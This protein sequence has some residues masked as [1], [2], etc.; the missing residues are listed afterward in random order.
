[1]L[2]KTQHYRACYQQIITYYQYAVQIIALLMAMQ[3]Y[4]S[5]VKFTMA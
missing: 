1:M 5:Q 3:V 2:Q 4:D